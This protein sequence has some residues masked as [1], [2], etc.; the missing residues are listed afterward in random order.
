MKIP[1]DR[2]TGT[3][4]ANVSELA[5]GDAAVNRAAADCP[6]AEQLPAIAAAVHTIFQLDRPVISPGESFRAIWKSCSS[7][8]RRWLIFVSIPFPCLISRPPSI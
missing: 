5:G 2:E 1:V 3:T 7:W 4:L 6:A 8:R